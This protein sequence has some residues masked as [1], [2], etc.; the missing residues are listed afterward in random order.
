MFSGWLF[1]LARNND[2]AI[3]E[4]RQTIAMHDPYWV[5][6]LILARV[7]EQQR[8][9]PAALAEL[10]DA[11]EQSGGDV[12]GAD[13][14]PGI[15]AEPYAELA[16]WYTLTGR[17]TDALTIVRELERERAGLAERRFPYIQ[18]TM[19]AAVYGAL[20][21][22]D[23]AFRSLQE[24]AQERDLDAT[25]INADPAFDSL[26]SDDRF[27]KLLKMVNWPGAAK[28]MSPPVAR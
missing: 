1:Y 14:K 5:A 19:I 21:D 27:A 17:P 9:W 10:K 2:A 13:I 22:V 4:L 16:R 23:R 28:L 12:S 24:A 18:P 20:G 3:P 26:L 8:L 25:W 15:I 6:H 11:I 7:Y